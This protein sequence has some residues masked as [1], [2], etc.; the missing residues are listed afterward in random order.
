MLYT[1]GSVFHLK[2][3]VQSIASHEKMVRPV[4]QTWTLHLQCAKH[5]QHVMHANGGLQDDIKKS[6]FKN[7]IGLNVKKYKNK[8]E[9][10]E[11]WKQINGSSVIRE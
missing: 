2:Q 11:I 5:T 9:M 3:F 8:L 10:K 6:I 4:R 1:N 7:G